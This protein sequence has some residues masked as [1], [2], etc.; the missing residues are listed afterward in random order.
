MRFQYTWIPILLLILASGGCA[1]LPVGSDEAQV[2]LIEANV[3]L[4]GLQDR[5]E[6]LYADMETVRQD[7]AAFYQ[8]PGWPEMRQIILT[9]LSAEGSE[10]DDTNLQTVAETA[11]DEWASRW[12]E[13]WEDRFAEYL[14]MVRRCTA[15]EARRI[16][17]QA[18]LFGVQGKFLGVSV[19][20]YSR[21]RYEQ[22]MASD[23][24][25]ELLS[26]SAEDLGSYSLDE[27]GLYE[28][29]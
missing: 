18:E 13:P 29:R 26:R 19:A 3:A 7:L 1:T 6:Q 24:V 22:G 12:G 14:G 16:A 23:E 17:L 8:E 28:V 4:G 11:T 21:G 20:N 9:V 25:V 27:V 2:R 5:I 15:L 10:D